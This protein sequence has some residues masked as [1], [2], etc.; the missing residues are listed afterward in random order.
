MEGKIKIAV[1]GAFGNMNY[2]DDL[3][4]YCIQKIFKDN[5]KYSLFFI[6]ENEY[7][8]LIIPEIKLIKYNSI[9]FLKPYI[10]LYGGGTQFACFNESKKVYTK[11]YEKYI[12]NPLLFVNK[13]R[14][15]RAT[16]YIRNIKTINALGLGIGPFISD[17]DG[18]RE[19]QTRKVIKRM[20]YIAVRDKLSL[21]Y[22]NKWN[23]GKATLYSDI[24]YYSRYLNII[25]RDSNCCINEV[26]LIIRD[27]DKTDY[28]T[29][30]VNK[31]L[32]MRNEFKRL[33]IKY[34]YISF[35]KISDKKVIGM[36]LEHGENVEQWDPEKCSIKNFMETLKKYNIIITARYH[37]AVIATLFDR[38]FIS[39]DIEP[40][41]AMIADLFNMPKWQAPYETERLVE[42]FNDISRNYLVYK[43][44]IVDQRIIQEKYAFDMISNYENSYLSGKTGSVMH[45]K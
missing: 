10:L 4:A 12:K 39:I 17:R 28:G 9:P 37:G 36:L 1:I 31:I 3:L 11:Q 15:E 20:D 35:S 42:I 44:K 30:Y 23:Q 24:V 43:N 32:N 40:K 27:W 25:N 45:D 29:Y 5:T 41:L 26:A 21:Q 22:C 38:P 18:Q 19:E 7:F 33:G 16:W 2:G 6:C 8:K 14:R 34:K 13:A